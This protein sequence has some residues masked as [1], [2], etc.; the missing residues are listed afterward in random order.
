MIF[1]NPYKVS[2]DDKK[3]FVGPLESFEL[4]RVNFILKCKLLHVPVKNFLVEL[5]HVL[6]VG[7]HQTNQKSSFFMIHLIFYDQHRSTRTL[8]FY[9]KHKVWIFP[10]I[11][12]PF[13]ALYD[14][15][16][17]LWFL[18][19]FSKKWDFGRIS[20]NLDEFGKS[21]FFEKF[22]RNHRSEFLS[23]GAGKGL[24]ISENI[25]TLSLE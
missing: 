17:L 5:C 20:W 2:R 25:Y 21:H 22:A 18:A 3:I 7:I 12:S 10:E 9:S 4:F 11:L 16:L 1:E 8:L 19:N 6:A 23:Y 13:A 24:K 15:N 14:K